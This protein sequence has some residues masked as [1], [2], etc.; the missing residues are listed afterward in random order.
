MKQLRF[1]FK[2]LFVTGLFFVFFRTSAQQVLISGTEFDPKPGKT[3][4]SWIGIGD[5][6]TTGLLTPTF[7]VASDEPSDLDY[8]YSTAT[9]NKGEA[10]A[11]HFHDG[12]HYAITKN[13]I[14]LDSIH[15][16]DAVENDYGI[17]FGPQRLS[18]NKTLLQMNVVG[19][20]P[21]SKAKVVIRYRS[22]IDD[23]K[24]L[25]VSDLKCG[26][27][28]A[29]AQ[30]KVAINADQYNQTAGEDVTQLAMGA[31]G[32]YSNANVTVD[33]KGRVTININ[34]VNSYS[35]DCHSF[36]I[37][38]IEVFGEITPEIYSVD[39][40]QICAGEFANLRSKSIY[41]GATYQWYMG[42]TPITGAMAE[43]YSFESPA[44]PDNYTFRLDVTYDGVTFSSNVLKVS[45]EKC[46]EVILP[47][48]STVPASRKIV[49][50]ED[51]GEF[52]LSDKTGMTYKVWDYK[53]ISN[54][55]QLTKTTTTPFRYP[56]DEAP[57]GCTYSGSR[58]PLND[59]YY[60]VAGVLTSYNPIDGMEGAH[61]EWANRV[62]GQTNPAEVY[63]DHSGEL[64]GCALF[65][66]C[67]PNTKGQN[68]YE[69]KI[70]N[71]CQ[72]RQ[73]FFE[74]YFTVFTNSANGKYNP[75]DITIKLTEIGNETNS[76]EIQG[77]ATIQ[78]EG[79]TGTW[80]KLAGQIFLEKND[81]I[82]LQV[83]N[84]QNADVNGNDLVLDD[85][86]IKAC[87]APSLQAYYDIN[88]FDTDTVTC[89]NNDG[90]IT[91]YA[92]PSDMLEN[93]F[94]GKTNTYYQYQWTMDPKDKTSWKNVASITQEKFIMV[95]TV[96]F[97]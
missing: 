3:T 84:N 22:V 63:Y 49:Y 4:E 58:G 24:D 56:L 16:I 96:P 7:T 40:Q 70:M 61:L 2:F 50:K 33:T 23:K 6:T 89:D 80:V 67:T 51:F 55:N 93:Y 77:I 46:C 74:C 53:D 43:S 8:D 45:S 52:D 18:A 83:V 14:I 30:F 41:N 60:T 17:V 5:I 76:E 42:G 69:R 85:I 1:L 10:I 90:L 12:E 20:T 44:N 88:T 13:P 28:S 48:G 66:N 59:G 78:S 92:K 25:V 97:A 39:G 68:I 32:T 86:I 91:V 64:G 75:V 9:T 62:G 65:I 35:G 82:L 81:A 57:L 73:L 26:N 15:Y 36:E 72:N 34:G 11:S 95:G 37:T 31:D 87:A 38:S 21:G 27:G 94:G 71:L 19:L 29:R 54:P 79:G 47:D